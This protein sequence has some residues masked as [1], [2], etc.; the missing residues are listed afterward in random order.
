MNYSVTGSTS[1]IDNQI[2]QDLVKGGHKLILNYSNKDIILS[3]N[4]HTI[5][6]KHFNMNLSENTEF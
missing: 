6:I 1:V 5:Y 2:E 4:E 3:N